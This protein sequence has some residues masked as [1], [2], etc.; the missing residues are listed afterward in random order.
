MRQCDNPNFKS[1]ACSGRAKPGLAYRHFADRL[2]LNV[3]SPYVRGRGTCLCGRPHRSLLLQPTS[4]CTL[5]TGSL[6]PASVPLRPSFYCHIPPSLSTYIY[7]PFD[8]NPETVLY[9]PPRHTTSC[10]DRSLALPSP[11]QAT[12]SSSIQKQI[13]ALGQLGTTLPP[14]ALHASHMRSYLRRL[15]DSCRAP[16]S[17]KSSPTCPT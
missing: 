5:V 13:A 3:P 16:H 17:L 14:R 2:L 9:P 6:I 12:A 8:I 11:N 1:E 7:L 15:R 10:R 4:A